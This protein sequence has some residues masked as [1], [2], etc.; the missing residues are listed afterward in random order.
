MARHGPVRADGQARSG[1]LALRSLA[2]AVLQLIMETDVEGLIGAGWHE[3]S[4]ERTT[5]RN[6]YRRRPRLGFSGGI[7]LVGLLRG[8]C[9]AG[10]K[11]RCHLGHREHG[12][13]GLPATSAH[14]G[15]F[16]SANA[17]ARHRQ[18]DPHRGPGD[19]QHRPCNAGLEFGCGPSSRSRFGSISL[20]N[21]CCRHGH[22]SHPAG[23]GLLSRDLARADLYPVRALARSR[24][25]KDLKRRKLGAPERRAGM[26][27]LGA[28]SGTPGPTAAPPRQIVPKRPVDRFTAT[29]PNHP[30]R[31]HKDSR[32]ALP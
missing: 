29:R 20:R 2:E 32:C 8:G 3:R 12:L 15:T 30:S 28:H 14:R 4:A 21:S 27:K 24:Q 10:S 18:H 19:W 1:R 31:R 17:A 23:R 25:I 16:L 7:L 11:P 22:R 13:C 9:A 5:W 6:G 26:P